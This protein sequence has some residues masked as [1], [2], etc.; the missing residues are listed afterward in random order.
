MEILN[1]NSGSLSASVTGLTASTNYL[2]ELNDLITGNEYSASA[3][4]N[5][6]GTV[7]F[8]MPSNFKEYTAKL[9]AS[10]KKI[11]NDDLV[12]IFNIDI[13]RPY[14]NISSIVTALKVTNTQATEYERLARYIIDSHTGGFEYTRKKKEF[15]GDNSDQLLIDEP[16]TGKIYSILEN[17]EI[18]FERD[19]SLKN[20]DQEFVYKKQLN[21]IVQNLP[22]GNNRVDYTKVWRDRYLDVEFYDGYEYSVDADF[23]WKVIPQDIQDATDM[24]IQDIATDSLKYVNRYIESFDNDDF[25]I[26][27]AKNWTASTGNRVVDRILEKYQKPI[28]VGVF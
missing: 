24:L 16:I 18:M 4:S 26:K 12:K 17:N 7:V 13:V 1:Y 14:T 25:K 8:T 28:R 22:N 23:G 11:S 3:T 19:D 21:A 6:S 2:I 20:N 15:I 5:V 9:A 27:F 10:V